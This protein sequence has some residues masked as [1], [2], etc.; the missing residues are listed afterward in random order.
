MAF[1]RFPPKT[2]HMKRKIPVAPFVIWARI[3]FLIAILTASAV[4]ARGQA[5]PTGRGGHGVKLY[6]AF[7][8]SGSS[9]GSVMQM[10]NTLGYDFTKSLGADVILP[11]YFVLPPSQKDGFAAPATG[12]GNVALDARGSLDLWL[13]DYSPTATVAFPTG[14]TTKGFS[15]GSITYD[16]DNNFEHDFGL[17]APFLDVDVGNSLDNGSNPARKKIQRPYLTLGNVANFT[18]GPQFHLPKRVTLSGDI[19]YTLPWGPQTLLSRIVRPGSTGK[20]LHNRRYEIASKT[21][22]G[23]T[24]IQDEGFDA[25]VAYSPTRYLDLTVAF[26]RSVRF[27]L[28][29]FSF[30]VGFNLSKMFGLRT[31]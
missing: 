25:S 19:F 24:L 3:L 9:S 21:I 2:G 8:D 15:T 4:R 5:E 16:L 23:A 17:V 12:L 26:N 10:S 29:T 22:G 27:D 18:A 20:A 13:V 30:T 14:S 7:E 28:D 31:E 11:L 6:V 1:A